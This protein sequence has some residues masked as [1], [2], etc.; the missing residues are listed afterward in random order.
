MAFDASYDSTPPTGSGVGNREQ[1]LDLTTVLAPR[2]AP[3]YG[4]LP[5][6]AATADL[7]EWTVD[8]LA[9]ADKDNAVEEGVDIGETRG[10]SFD[11]QF[12]SLTRLNNRLQHFRGGFNV[13][14]KQ[15]IFDSVT[16]VRVQEAEEKAASQLLRDIESALASDNSAVAGASGAAGKFRGLGQWINNSPT[17]DDVAAVPTAFKTPAASVLSDSNEDLTESRFNGMLTSVFE[18]TGEQGDHVLVAGTTVRNAIID[19]FTRVQTVQAANNVTD[20]SPLIG[21]N[22]TVFN[23]GD[24]TDIT[25]N[26]E[27]FQGPYGIVKIMSANPKT[28]PDQKRAYLLD[29]SLLG[30]AEG[31]SMGSTMLEDQGGGPRGYI[32]HMGTLICRGPNGLGKITNFA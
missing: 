26:V 21:G 4:M 19:G 15:E 3:I 29:P 28:L 6:Q 27:I 13:S 9:D 10:G 1:L 24:G 23:Q 30:Y 12:G 11:A 32:D 7:V 31:L 16:P 20:K 17:S 8:N 14:K 25:Y 22:G 5:K 18:E 2:Q